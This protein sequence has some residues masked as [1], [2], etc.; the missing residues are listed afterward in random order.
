MPKTN[1]KLT[2]IKRIG[3]SKARSAIWLCSCEC[4]N[5]ITLVAQDLNSGHTKTCGCSRIK[6]GEAIPRSPNR[7]QKQKRQSKEY[8]AWQSM[9]QRCFRK[10][11]VG[12]HRYG[13]RGI[14]VCA[15]WRASYTDFLA[16]VGRA[17]SSKHSLDRINNNGNYEHGNVRWATR[18]EQAANR[19]NPTNRFVWNWIK[20]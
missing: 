3:T 12:Y 5:S 7:H 14:T 13:G 11:R 19:T 17:P 18:K 20:I 15:K 16:D 6:H 2:P 1:G 9:I 8:T 10:T 4:G